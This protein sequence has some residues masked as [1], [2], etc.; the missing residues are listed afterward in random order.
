MKFVRPLP[1]AAETARILA[2]HRTRPPPGAPP[3][4]G[5]ALTATLKALDTRYGRGAG[6]LPMRWR[7]IVGEDIARRTEPVRLLKARAGGQATLEIRAEGAA[8]VLIQHQ[9][10]DILDRVNLFL[11]PNAVERLRVVQGRLKSAPARPPVRPRPRPAAAPLDAA[12]EARLQASL[13]DIP[14]GRL[15]AALT[16]LGRGVFSR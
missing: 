1:D 3:T 14:E 10:N 4:A 12:R 2:S 8:A 5:R 7:E 13:A 6:A 11:G 9:A 16:R 15:K